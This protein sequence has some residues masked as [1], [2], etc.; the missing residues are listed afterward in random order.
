MVERLSDDMRN[1]SVGLQRR[2]HRE[3]SS[4]DTQASDSDDDLTPR[5]RRKRPGKRGSKNHLHVAFRS[6]LRE[7]KLLRGKH[8]SLP[9]SSPIE[10]IQAFNRD[11]DC[12]PTLENLFIDWSDSLEKSSWNTELISLIVVDLQA[13]I[14][15]GTYAQVLFHAEASLD[16]LR[17]LC[18]DKL[19]RTQYECRQHTWDTI[20]RIINRL[21][22]NGVSGD[23][24]DTPIGATPKVVRRVGLPWLNPDVTQLLHAVESY[25]AAT[26]EENM[27]IPIGNSSLP[28]VLEPKRTA[29]NS[30]AIQRLPRNW[31]N[32]N[33]YQA[34]STSA[35]ALL[36]ARK[37]LILPTLEPYCSQKHP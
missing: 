10:S 8:G 31:Y 12:C 25:A 36:G 22:V 32:D 28:R 34:N 7:K 27:T 9:Q 23:E 24:T 35:R 2:T 6:Y 15:N 13:K 5:P 19:R 29:Q 16:N 21:D 11:H 1:V 17:S 18:I 37:S 4:S 3:D 30:I 20:G 14:R 33:W 26:H